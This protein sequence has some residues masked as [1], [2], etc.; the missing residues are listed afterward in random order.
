MLKIKWVDKVTN[1]QVLEMKERNL[2]PYGVVRC[3]ETAEIRVPG[4]DY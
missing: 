1:G 2:G 4:L 3:K